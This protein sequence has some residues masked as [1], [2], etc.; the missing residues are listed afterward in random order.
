MRTELEL[1]DKLAIHGDAEYIYDPEV[2]YLSWHVSTGGNIET[3][4]MEAKERR[5]GYGTELYRRMVQRLIDNK[6]EP[7]HSVF[8]FRLGMNDAAKLFYA[9][10]G[11]TEVNLGESIYRNGDCVI[12]WITWNK[13]VDVLLRHP[14]TNCLMPKS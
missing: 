1:K 4:Y 9:S 11:W 2:G 5:K 12:L 13:L 6:Q 3:L 10:M 7:Y 14:I 8:C